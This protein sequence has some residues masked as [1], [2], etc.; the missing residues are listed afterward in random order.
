[1]EKLKREG[2]LEKIKPYVLTYL[3]AIAI[4]LLVGL[5][6]A[7]L[8]KDNMTVYSELTKPPLAPPSWLF[9]VVWTVLYTLM[10]VSSATALISRTDNNTKSLKCALEFYAVSLILNFGWSIIFFNIGAYFLALIWLGL[11][12]YT[13]VRTVLCYLPVSKL[14]AIL[15]IPYILWLLFAFYLNG[16]YAFV[17]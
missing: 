12:I 17:M 13:V 14:A 2:I 4:P 9:P 10:G 1:M 16:F 8:T 6:S 3:V 11:L 15:Q 7:F 5:F